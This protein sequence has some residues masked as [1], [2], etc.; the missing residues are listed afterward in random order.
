MVLVEITP[1][2]NKLAPNNKI[3][4]EYILGRQISVLVTA[5][6]CVI[7]LGFSWVYLVRD[8]QHLSGRQPSITWELARNGEC[9]AN[10]RPAELD[11]TF[12]QDPFAR[13]SGQ[14]IQFEKHCLP[15]LSKMS[16]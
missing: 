5:S 4:K 10:P 12:Q 7:T 9:Q 6:K 2:P 13:W 15:P 3:K 11:S 1:L 8:A 16:T 14:T